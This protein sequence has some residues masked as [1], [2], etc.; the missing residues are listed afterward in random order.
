MITFSDIQ[1]PPLLIESCITLSVPAVDRK[2][3]D[4]AT[5]IGVILDV[6]NS[7]YQIETKSGIIKG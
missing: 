4:F 1:F 3:L 2:P 7:A 6:K 5:I